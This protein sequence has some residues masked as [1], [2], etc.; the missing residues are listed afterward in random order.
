M[1]Y[2]LL[3]QTNAFFSPIFDVPVGRPRA[4]SDLLFAQCKM[5]G[6]IMLI[7]LNIARV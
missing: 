6:K 5:K 1:E 4:M 2:L 7:V 3:P